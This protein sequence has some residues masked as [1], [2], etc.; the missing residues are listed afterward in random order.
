MIIDSIYAIV[1]I[2]I[3]VCLCGCQNMAAK[4]DIVTG[5]NLIVIIII[6]YSTYKL[7]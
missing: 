5:F 7:C 2:I 3:T 4:R 6:D 1:S